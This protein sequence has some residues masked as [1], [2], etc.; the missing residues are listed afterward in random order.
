MSSVPTTS[1]QAIS[2]EIDQRLEK[3]GLKRS[4]K[5]TV[6]GATYDVTKLK[7]IIEGKTESLSET[8]KDICDNLKNIFARVHELQSAISSQEKN[9]TQLEKGDLER[10]S[11]SLKTVQE[12]KKHYNIEQKSSNLFIRF[13]RAIRDIFSPHIYLENAVNNRNLNKTIKILAERINR[14]NSN[15]ASLENK[16]ISPLDLTTQQ[17]VLHSEDSVLKTEETQILA[18]EVPQVKEERVLERKDLQL[19]VESPVQEPLSENKDAAHKAEEKQV[20]T[21]EN[22]EVK[23]SVDE[24]VKDEQILAK[25]DSQVESVINEE[26]IAQE[27]E[28][29]IPSKKLRGQ[30]DI[31]EYL[32]KWKR[33]L[34]NTPFHILWTDRDDKV[35]CTVVRNGEETVYDL[36][37]DSVTGSW[38]SGQSVFF[39]Y[40]GEQA[41]FIPLETEIPPSFIS[42]GASLSQAAKERLIKSR[43]YSDCSWEE[44]TQTLA[45]IRESGKDLEHGKVVKVIFEDGGK[46]FLASMDPG[47]KEPSIQRIKKDEIFELSRGEG[48]L[49]E[50]VSEPGNSSYISISEY[51]ELNKIYTNQSIENNRLEIDRWSDAALGTKLEDLKKLTRS[52]GKDAE[53]AYA[54]EAPVDK[55][56]VFNSK[57]Q[58]PNKPYTLRYIDDS[59]E[60]QEALLYPVVSGIR[61]QWIPHGGEEIFKDQ[62]EIADRLKLKEIAGVNKKSEEKE[63]EI[64]KSVEALSELQNLAINSSNAIRK[65][66][67]YVSKLHLSAVG[68]IAIWVSTKD[69]DA[70]FSQYSCAIIKK[71]DSTVEHTPTLKIYSLDIRSEVGKIIFKDGE[72][73]VASIPSDKFSLSSIKDALSFDAT[74]KIDDLEKEASEYDKRKNEI[75]LESKGRGKNLE[76]DL[77]AFMNIEKEKSVGTYTFSYK[78]A[79][80]QSL[81]NLELLYIAN[82]EKGPEIKRVSM[83]L[84]SSPGLIQIESKSFNSF[85]EVKSAYKLTRN[86]SKAYSEMYDLL[87]VSRQFRENNFYQE[88]FRKRADAERALR[89]VLNS[90]SKVEPQ[91]PEFCWLIRPYSASEGGLFASIRDAVG[92]WA[93][94]ARDF[95]NRYVPGLIQSNRQQVDYVLTIANSGSEESEEHKI[96]LLYDPGNQPYKYS[97]LFGDKVFS[98]VED[99]IYAIR[100]PESVTKPDE[101]QKS[102]ILNCSYDKLQKQL[103]SQMLKQNSASNTQSTAVATAKQAERI[104]VTKESPNDASQASVIQEQ[105]NASMQDVDSSQSSAHQIQSEPQ[106]T[107]EEKSDTSAL[108]TKLKDVNFDEVLSSLKEMNS[109][110]LSKDVNLDLRVKVL[111]L[112]E[113]NTENFINLIKLCNSKTHSAHVLKNIKEPVIRFAVAVACLVPTASG[114]F[115]F[116]YLEKSAESILGEFK[117]DEVQL[118]NQ[119]LNKYAGFK[120]FYNSVFSSGLEEFDIYDKFIEKFPLE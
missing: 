13:F 9:S 116:T 107:P 43:F 112:T 25:Q 28:S 44:V 53:G 27:K 1:I 114:G 8:G 30:E 50:L 64:K 38:K 89:E 3:L 26:I 78:E 57:S 118:I 84:S 72:T 106:A 100:N 83:D 71:A 93:D 58:D 99:V 56:W 75:V 29:F 69:R 21:N 102:S 76:G 41:R 36:E 92:V 19:E 51:I 18:K 65:L 70:N 52:L 111:N 113:F 54:M 63:T 101:A 47:A 2:T 82:G 115:K 32:D 81:N 105:A 11:R 5:I 80:Y 16:T 98:S 68:G 40:D 15:P 86:P 88:A 4:G 79:P 94:Q 10:I 77:R 91:K 61:L 103:T 119:T 109:K 73:V 42:L 45:T 7:K 20:S 87:E 90:I 74:K 17:H 33:R 39:K 110:L 12:L 66:N 120:N 31:K 67:T 96:S 117:A 55:G 108:K 104:I 46:L 14:S 59:G 24:L 37:R 48:D 85:D 97:V 62:K 34:V 35:K 6:N 23:K 60:I 95:Y 49:D 22:P